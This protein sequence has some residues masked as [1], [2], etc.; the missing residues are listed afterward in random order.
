[1]KT[2]NQLGLVVAIL[3]PLSALAMPHYEWNFGVNERLISY[4]DTKGSFALESGYLFGVTGNFTYNAP[5]KFSVKADVAQGHVDYRTNIQHSYSSK[6]KNY[7]FNVM[8]TAAKPIYYMQR[9]LTPYIGVGYRYY[10]NDATNV[11][12]NQTIA[13]FQSKQSTFYMPIGFRTQVARQNNWQVVLNAEYD[14]IWD[15]TQKTYSTQIAGGSYV[16]ARD[17][18]RGIRLS[19]DWQTHSSYGLVTVTPYYNRYTFKGDEQT[20]PGTNLQISN[21]HVTETGVA[22]TLNFA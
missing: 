21:E 2:M 19:A 7:L 11:V 8:A 4:Q 6:P 14:L 13:G 20:I 15:G 16:S 17:K 22:F 1:M 12:M 9:H 18:G 5:I 10:N 3:L